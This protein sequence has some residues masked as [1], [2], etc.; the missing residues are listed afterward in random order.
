[1]EDVRS[2]A[3]QG[4]R[5]EGM[6][7]IELLKA[8]CCCSKTGGGLLLC[9]DGL[10][11]KY[12]DRWHSPPN[13]RKKSVHTNQPVLVLE[14]RTDKVAEKSCSFRSSQYLWLKSQWRN[15]LE[16][17]PV[18]R[19]KDWMEGGSNKVLNIRDCMS[20]HLSVVTWR[21]HTSL[22]KVPILTFSVVV[23]SH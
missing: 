11:K 17:E 15:P 9:L 3:Y 6:I 23:L 8:T 21:L 22:P 1:M 7:E 4:N 13:Q 20:P 19:E 18:I 16:G 2:E 10:N 14:S 5:P 12:H